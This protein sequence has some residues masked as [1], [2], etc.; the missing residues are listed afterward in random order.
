MAKLWRLRCG[1]LSGAVF[2]AQVAVSQVLLF[3]GSDEGSEGRAFRS[4]RHE[5][6]TNKARTRHEQ[7]FR[8]FVPPSFYF[9]PFSG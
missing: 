6:G 5:Q 9:P 2:V 1:V 7:A 3:E 4:S 8:Y